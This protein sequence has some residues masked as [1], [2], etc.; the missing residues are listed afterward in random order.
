MYTLPKIL[1]VD[2]DF[3]IRQILKISLQNSFEVFEAENGSDALTQLKTV[4]PQVVL[5]DIDM[6]GIRGDQVLDVI[7]LLPELYD[8]R[9]AIV[10][11]SIIEPD[12]TIYNKAN[13]IFKKPFTPSEIV[14]WVRQQVTEFETLR[15]KSVSNFT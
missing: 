10:S 11:G 8:V 4:F 5:L 14:K 3:Y 9:V 15:K 2:D 6:P 7:C 1:I 12:T 13:A